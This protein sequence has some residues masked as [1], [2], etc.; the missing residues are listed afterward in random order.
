MSK[1]VSVLTPV[2]QWPSW[3]QFLVFGPHAIL[4]GILTWVWWPKTNKDWRR[5]GIAF[6]Y[7][8][9]FY[10]VMYYVFGF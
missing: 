3:V 2:S 5:F 1:I 7:L 9:V 10:L 4:M 8:I 6:A